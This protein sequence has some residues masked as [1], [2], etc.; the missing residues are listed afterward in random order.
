MLYAWCNGAGYINKGGEARLARSRLTT[1][2][3]DSQISHMH[4]ERRPAYT[5]KPFAHRM[6]TVAAVLA[7]ARRDILALRLYIHAMIDN[8]QYCLAVQV[9]Y[10]VVMTGSHVMHK[11]TD[12]ACI[13]D[14][15]DR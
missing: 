7:L 15:A 5:A 6:N 10:S 11:L 8:K 12:K 9:H 4:C 13:A 2:A 1:K 3:N 14:E